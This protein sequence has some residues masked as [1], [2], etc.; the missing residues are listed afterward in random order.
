M[1][2]RTAV[3]QKREM[4]GSARS[5]KKEGEYRVGRIKRVHLHFMIPL[6]A[7]EA[8]KTEVP[9]NDTFDFSAVMAV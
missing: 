7:A 8:A 6:C 3:Q 1:E 5:D 4:G 9:E 2:C